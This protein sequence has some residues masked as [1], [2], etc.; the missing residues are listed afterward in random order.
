MRDFSSGTRTPPSVGRDEGRE[1]VFRSVFPISD[2]GE[3]VTLEYMGYEI[4]LWESK[5]NEYPGL[6]G[7]GV[8]DDD[9]VE[10]F[11]R[12]KH[13]ADEC[14]QRG[15]TY[16]APLRVMLRLTVYE[17]DELTKERRVREVKEQKVYLGE[18]PLMTDNGTFIINGT[19]RVVVSQMHRSPGAFF[20]AD[21]AKPTAKSAFTARLIPYRGSWS[22][23]MDFEFD[24]KELLFVPDRQAP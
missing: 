8:K 12:Q 16:V 10:V 13:E 18:I 3:N 22:G 17:L 5:G 15:M 7:P 1:G 19:E 4:G 23:L 9:G 6:G 21:K 14:R 11:C 20:S 2:S 24:S